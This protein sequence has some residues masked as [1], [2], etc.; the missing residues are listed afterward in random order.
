[1]KKII[2]FASCLVFSAQICAGQALS[3]MLLP[4]DPAASPCSGGAF[5][6]E[7]YMAAASFSG[8]SC[9]LSFQDWGGGHKSLD[10]GAVLGLN[11]LSFGLIL[12]DYTSSSY[13]LWSSDGY[14]TGQF[15]PLEMYGQA[16]LAYRISE[17]LAAGLSLGYVRSKLAPEVHAGAFFGGASIMYSLKKA[18]FALRLSNFGGALK[19]SSSASVSPLSTQLSFGV[20][21]RPSEYLYLNTELSVLCNGQMSVS[22]GFDLL[23]QEA[24]HLF[25][26]A[27]YG[28]L[29]ESVMPDYLAAGAGL[30]LFGLGLDAQAVLNPVFGLL[31]GLS[32]SYRF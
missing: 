32:L 4:S 8:S 9:A 17:H 21:Y 30:R 5:S 10:A 2:F 25:A 18:D 3:S 14:I 11:K 29:G 16:G 27:N 28:F 26:R 12:R 23:P 24:F 6:A 1:M 7:S 20:N 22:A 13:N 15:S 19:Y 31:P